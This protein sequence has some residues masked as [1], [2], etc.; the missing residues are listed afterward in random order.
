M[1]NYIKWHVA[2]RKNRRKEK[3]KNVK[4]GDIGSYDGA[5]PGGGGNGI[6][7]IPDGT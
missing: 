7:A 4:S 1:E 5:C 6:P 3:K 2:G